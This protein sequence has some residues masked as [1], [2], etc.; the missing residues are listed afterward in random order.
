[1]H[2]RGRESGH[3]LCGLEQLEDARY[4]AQDLLGLGLRSTM[5][6]CAWGWLGLTVGGCRPVRACWAWDRQR[7]TSHPC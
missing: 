3:T 1:V 5:H 6:V 2:Q 7:C 4:L